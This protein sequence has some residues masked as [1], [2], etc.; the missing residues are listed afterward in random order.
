VRGVEGDMLD[1]ENQNRHQR[2]KQDIVEGERDALQKYI[3]EMIRVNM[4]LQKELETFVSV[5]DSVIRTID[6]RADRVSPIREQ[7]QK[8]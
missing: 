3:D 8:S 7:I 6:K 2:E 1:Y 4:D 5:D